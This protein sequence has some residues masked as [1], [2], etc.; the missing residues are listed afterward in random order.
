MISFRNF[1]LRRG[2]RLLLSGVDLAMHAGWRLGV[3]GGTGRTDLDV[4]Q[5][6]SRVEA[7]SRHAGVYAS[8]AWSGVNVRAGYTHGWHDVDSR[9]QVAFPGFTDATGARYDAD[10]WQAFVEAGY[11]VDVGAWSFEPYLQYAHVELDTDGDAAQQVSRMC[12]DERAAVCHLTDQPA[13]RAALIRVAPN[14]HRLLL[15]THHI[16]LDGWSMP[17]LLQEIFA[18]FSRQR[19]PAA[20]PYRSFITWLADRDRDA[21]QAARRLAALALGPGPLWIGAFGGA[22]RAR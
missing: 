15:T 17:I 1:A 4:R 10:A 6:A 22:A 5:R 3:F 18:G 16:V 7:D 14:R 20:T 8:T 21:A 2:E 19:L 12:A 9:R 13:F 11:R